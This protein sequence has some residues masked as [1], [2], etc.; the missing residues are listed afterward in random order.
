M[1]YSELVTRNITIEV[2]RLSMTSTV[3]SK[4]VILRHCT[5][6]VQQGNSEIARCDYHGLHYLLFLNLLSRVS[7][8]TILSEYEQICNINPYASTH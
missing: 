8:K 1:K 6:T 7:R 5:N 2:A 4:L 3:G